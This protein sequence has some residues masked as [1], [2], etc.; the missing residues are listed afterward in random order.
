MSLRM[1]TSRIAPRLMFRRS[2]ATTVESSKGPLAGGTEAISASRPVLSPKETSTV[3]EPLKDQDSK[4]K[5]FHVYRWNPDAPSDKPRMQS[6]TLD[7]NKTGPMMLDALIRIKNELDPTLTFRRS[8]REG[9]CGSCAMN[10]D[11]VNTLACLCMFLAL[12]PLF[13][14]SRPLT[15]N[16]PH[17]HRHQGRVPHLPPPSHLRRQGSRS[18]PYP[19]LQAV[20][21]HQALL[22]TRDRS[23]GREFSIHT[24]TLNHLHTNTFTRAVSTANPPLSAASS[25]VCMSAFSAP[26]AALPALHTGGTRRSTSVP[27]SSSSPTAGSPTR[28]MREP[29]LA[30]TPSTTPCPCTAATPS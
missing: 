7:L 30:R 21:V 23:R 26:A 27:P 11:G 20:Q 10:I 6:Y 3:K 4:I 18:R 2:M 19:V 22:A 1:A 29:P 16:R 12:F 24:L 8:C 25:T 9:I 15:S 17:S 13:S 14:R 28:V 5:T